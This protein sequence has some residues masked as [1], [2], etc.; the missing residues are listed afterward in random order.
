M[1]IL[2]RFGVAFFA[3]S[4]GGAFFFWLLACPY[5]GDNNFRLFMP[6]S[7]LCMASAFGELIIIFLI[8]CMRYVFT[9]KGIYD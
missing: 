4:M 8:C 3:M 2:K 6:F 7:A 1:E 9:G 5:L